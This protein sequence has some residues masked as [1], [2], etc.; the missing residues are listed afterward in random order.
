MERIVLAST[1]E[2]DLILD[3]FLGSGTTGVASVLGKRRFIG[4]DSDENF[5]QLAKLRIEDAY[6]SIPSN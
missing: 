6:S 1:D 5:L 4:I 2:N 3:P